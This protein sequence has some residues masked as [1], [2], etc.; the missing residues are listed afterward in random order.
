MQKVFK[1]TKTVRIFSVLSGLLFLICLIGSIF[2]IVKQD[3]AALIIVALGLYLD[4]IFVL[5]ALIE[6]K[7]TFEI[8]RDTLIFHYR[9]FSRSKKY[10][11]R[12][13]SLKCSDINHLLKLYRK[14]DGISTADTT[15]YQFILHDGTII[16]TYFYH[17]G[18]EAVQEID[19]FLEQHI[20]V[21]KM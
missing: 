9:V 5:V 21:I 14:G 13:V 10:N 15:E 11:R 12:N 3:Y 19:E 18:R 6:S 7:G 1:R 20:K 17:F 4:L 2:C 16:E 8:D